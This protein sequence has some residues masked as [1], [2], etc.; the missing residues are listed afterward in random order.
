VP[1]LDVADDIT[2]VDP[3]I[4]DDVVGSRRMGSWRRWKW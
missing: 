1:D 3:H 2:G 4:E